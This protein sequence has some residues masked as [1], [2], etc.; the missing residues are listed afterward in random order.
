[1]KPTLKGAPVVSL[2]SARKLGIHIKT[3][4]L[5]SAQVIDHFSWE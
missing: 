5:L 1:M 3:G 4:I 2:A